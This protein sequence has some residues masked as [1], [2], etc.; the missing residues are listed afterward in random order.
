MPVAIIVA[1]DEARGIGLKQSLPWHFRE[2]L[3]YFK[4]KTVGKTLLMGYDTYETLPIKPL[5]NRTTIVATRNRAVHEVGVNVTADVKATLQSYSQ[6]EEWLFVAGGSC[7]YT[8]AL[9]YANRL[10]ITKIPGVHK[11]DT[12]FP[13]FDEEIFE[14]ISIEVGSEVSFEVYERKEL[15]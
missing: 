11:V 13:V 8:Y 10:Y 3:Q 6:S 7:I 5:P 9:P 12:W 1:Y 4:A 14:R 2:D 15:I